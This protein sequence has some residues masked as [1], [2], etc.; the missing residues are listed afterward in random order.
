[1]SEIKTTIVMEYLE[2][3]SAWGKF[4]EEIDW[5]ISQASQDGTEVIANRGFWSARRW[6]H[7]QKC[8]LFS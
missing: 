5:E 8:A 1:M 6:K 7:L 3:P 2:P 4:A